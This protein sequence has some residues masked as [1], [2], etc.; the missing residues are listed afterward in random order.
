MI[1]ST[2]GAPLGGTIFAGQHGLESV[3]LRLIVPANS[4][5]GDGTYLPSTV[6]VALVEHGTPVV[7]CACAAAA[8]SKNMGIT[9]PNCSKLRP[10]RISLDF[11]M[12]LCAFQAAN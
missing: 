10:L 5:G 4:G 12:W 2:F 11:F 6:V 7:C 1:S 9:V 8:V 3:A